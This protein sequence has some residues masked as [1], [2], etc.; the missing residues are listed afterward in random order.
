MGIDQIEKEVRE[1]L[2]HQ[3]DA[4]VLDD[5]NIMGTLRDDVLELVK[6]LMA[7]EERFQ[8]EFDPDTT[9]DSIS[10]KGIV[11]YIHKQQKHFA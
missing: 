1:I 4:G 8:I 11:E 2:I 10:I 5:S 3:I 7:I 9:V 6:G